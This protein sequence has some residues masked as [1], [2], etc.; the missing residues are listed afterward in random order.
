MS[1][2]K[3]IFWAIVIV[4]GAVLFYRYHHRNPE[5]FTAYKALESI[6]PDSL[7]TVCGNPQDQ[8]KGVVVEDDGIR[9]LRYRD[10]AGNPIV[11][12]FISDDGEN[13][14][15]FGAWE[16]VSA[17]ETLGTPVDADEAARR[18][19]CSLKSAPESSAIASPSPASALA[20]ILLG[21]EIV[22]PHPAPPPTP[23]PTP[24]PT[25]QPLPNPTPLPSP[26][27]LPH[28]TPLPGPSPLPGGGAPRPSGGDEP[29]DS[30]G[31]GEGGGGSQS[32][33][34][35]AIIPC[36][37]DADPCKVLDYAEFAFEMNQAIQAERE[38]NFEKAM[39]IVKRHGVLVVQ[40]PDLELNR[41]QVVKAVFQLEAKVINAVAAQ[42]RA[43]VAKL[44]P[45][46]QETAEQKAQKMAVVEQ[47]DRA[48]RQT[49]RQA[50]E[51]SRPTRAQ[52]AEESAEA[53]QEAREER[54]SRSM[55]FHSEAYNQLVSIHMSGNWP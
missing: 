50:V 41:V 52:L 10:N 47:D 40:L 2:R 26:T 12:R 6:T 7:V 44:Q 49:W 20:A 8:S 21:Q 55:S 24:M 31:G 25:P 22:I 19:P 43:D 30:G 36:P 14:H 23:F 15:G 48:M 39:D 46:P 29:E 11:F 42:L 53:H 4:V 28:F 16:N 32:R 38:N 18:L 33:G 27:P 17:P 9:D 51:D 34:M 13:W 45:F 54:E 37:P 5:S 35:P 1:K 3:R